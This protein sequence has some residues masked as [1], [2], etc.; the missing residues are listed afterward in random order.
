M[1]QFC[2]DQKDDIFNYVPLTFHIRNN[3]QEEYE[4]LM[5]YEEGESKS[6][7]DRMLWIVKPG[8]NSNRGCGIEICRKAE[9]VRKH[10]EREKLKHP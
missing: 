1:K 2:D 7:K 5:Q 8:E 6:S 4:A 10:I 9:Q 3:C